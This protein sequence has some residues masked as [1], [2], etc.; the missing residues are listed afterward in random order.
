[1]K[2]D[3]LR[4]FFQ[5]P[6]ASIWKTKKRPVGRGYGSSKGRTAAKGHKGQWGTNKG[7]RPGFEGGQTPV[8]RR[9]PKRGGTIGSARRFKRTMV[10][11]SRFIDKK[12]AGKEVNVENLTTAFRVP[13]YYKR[14]KIVGRDKAKFGDLSKA[15]LIRCDKNKAK[16]VKITKETRKNKSNII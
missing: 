10:L 4:Q 5:Q 16:S 1:M 9:L 13:F 11:S 2:S 7:V 14:I 6:P 8:Y 15:T 12:L 3:N